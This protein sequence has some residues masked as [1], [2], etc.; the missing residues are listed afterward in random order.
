MQAFNSFPY[1]TIPQHRI[2]VHAWELPAGKPLGPS[3]E[4]WVHGKDLVLSSTL[5]LDPDEVRKACGLGSDSRLALAATWRAAGTTLRGSGTLLPL[6]S[7]SCGQQEFRM[8]L[9][10]PGQEISGRLD[11]RT[12][13]V[14][15]NRGACGDALSAVR[16]GSIL[17]LQQV[18]TD[19]EGES[20]MFPI[21]AVS[22]SQIKGW[23]PDALWVLE[24]EPSLVDLH[25]QFS[26]EARLYMNIDHPAVRA[27]RIASGPG[28]GQG[29]ALRSVLMHD[30]AENLM[31]AGLT[32]AE[33]V[34][35]E[36]FPHG[37]VGR[38][39][40]SLISSTFHGMGATQVSAE[41]KRNPG[42]FSSRIQASTNLL[43]TL[44]PA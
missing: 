16:P 5:A 32:R 12:A 43:A 21:C 11:I 14:L 39:L 26:A 6:P 20:P 37:S 24:W 4:G 22:F 1:L 13:V 31:L 18:S 41:S 35:G 7:D 34:D 28:S 38:V 30:L 19:L 33:E 3:L 36:E 27:F 2:E 23:S 29:N 15:I 25:A 9:T 10:V 17:W 8:A 42:W 44:G 40:S